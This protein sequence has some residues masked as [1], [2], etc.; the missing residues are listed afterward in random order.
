MHYDDIVS[1]VKVIQNDLTTKQ[2]VSIL[3]GLLRD[4]SEYDSIDIMAAAIRLEKSW[5]ED[6]V[7]LLKGLAEYADEEIDVDNYES[8]SELA[9]DVSEA[10]DVE[11]C[12]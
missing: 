5:T 9:Q 7:W 3:E 11:L 6:C 12:I 1:L 8:A 2:A 10:L 4:L